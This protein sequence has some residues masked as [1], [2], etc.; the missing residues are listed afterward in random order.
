MSCTEFLAD[1]VC[2]MNSVYSNQQSCLALS[3][4]S[5]D[6]TGLTSS[7]VCRFGHILLNIDSGLSQATNQSVYTWSLNNYYK[8]NNNINSLFFSK[9]SNK[10]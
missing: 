9:G 3:S 6:T 8:P 2:A 10:S 7:D 4:L 1:L 5:N